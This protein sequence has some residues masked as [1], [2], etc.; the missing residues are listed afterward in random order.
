[1][2]FAVCTEP[3]CPALVEGKGRC[4]AH[5]PA[6]KPRPTITQQGYGASWRHTRNAFIAAH[7]VCQ[8][9]GTGSHHP[10]CNGSATVADHDPLTRRELVRRGDPNPD[11]WSHLVAR[12]HLCH[13]RKS[14]LFDRAFGNRPKPRATDAV[15]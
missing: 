8:G 6:V 3:G 4:P 12:S 14:A 15:S 10:G 2:R 5:G 7:P 9:D 1:M 13:G 11:A